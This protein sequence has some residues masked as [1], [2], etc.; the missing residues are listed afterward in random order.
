MLASKNEELSVTTGSG[1]ELDTGKG[2]A[3]PIALNSCRKKEFT[4]MSRNL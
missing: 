3:T 1:P 2:L 4:P